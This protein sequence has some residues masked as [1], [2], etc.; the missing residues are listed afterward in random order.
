M[1]SSLVNRIGAGADR[2]RPIGMTVGSHP[3]AE[4]WCMPAVPREA[5]A[6]VKILIN[7]HDWNEGVSWTN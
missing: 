3:R 2:H 6:H 4:L 5:R 7:E 1:N